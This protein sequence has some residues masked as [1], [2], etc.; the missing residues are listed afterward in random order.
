MN[1]KKSTKRAL[2]SSILSLALCMTMLIGTT[3]AWFTDNV[4]SSNNIIKSGKLDVELKYKS[5]FDANWAQV[6]DQEEAIFNYDKWEP[7]YVDVK[8][9]QVANAGNLAFKYLLNII[10]KT[11]AAEGKANLA[12]VIDVYIVNNPTE[13]IERED[14][15]NMT[16]V[17]TLTSLMA[18]PDGA[19][20]G[21]LLPKGSTATSADE[22]VGSVEM[23]IALKMQE[24]AGNEY[25][26]LTVGGGFDIQLFATQYTWEN[27]SFD[28]QYDAN[29]PK[30]FT[31]N[32]VEYD[33][34]E[35]ALEAAKEGDIVYLSSTT[36]PIT[37]DKKIKLTIANTNI[38][39][40]D[41]VNAITVTADAT[42]TVE[43]YNSVVGGK[44]ADGINVAENVTLTL[45]GKGRLITSGNAEK[46]YFR[47]TKDSVEYGE[48]IS[49][50][51]DATYNGTGGS[52]IDVAGDIVIDGLASLTAKGY[53]I[54][55]FG[56]GGTTD[57]ITIKNSTIN[58]VR[59]AFA[60]TEMFIPG[61]AGHFYGKD[62]PE[63]G[64]AIGSSTDKAVI[65]I[66][67]STITRAEGGSKA[68]GIGARFWTGVEVNITD[69]NVTAIG[70][71]ASAG[72]G[73]SRVHQEATTADAITVN[74]KNSVI[75]AT[76]GDYAAGIGSGY[77][78]YA[79]NMAKAPTTKVTIDAG[80]KIVAKGGML[81]AGIGT[82]HNVLNFVG[83]IK[84]DTTNVKA[85][86]NVDDCCHGAL[87]SD[88][89]DVGLGAYKIEGIYTFV[90]NAD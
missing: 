47:K 50:T 86:Y 26:D 84:C 61:W 29:A 17:G 57:S 41:G 46:E 58:Y 79:D 78:T 12:D 39:A 75:N 11:V 4:T 62:E 88:T 18:D 55:G 64:A 27:D 28:N 72:I 14:L 71:N 87:C 76:G 38:V 3:F 33:T 16:K 89:E 23:G 42:I 60:G 6:T 53:G 63:G 80:S 7:G 74:I 35:K 2:I 22:V 69:S 31:V 45:T 40:A 32:G 59:G 43:G 10:P 25:Q 70:G 15:A 19:A 67:K 13:A 21:I 49:N 77:N 48:H 81:G 52:G 24:S 44:N 83:D 36:E 5:D 65:N 30:M 90:N 9:I 51:K 82:G 73:G 20:R 85:G 56:I 54:G 34:A 8:Y 1:N 37:I 66:E 68:A